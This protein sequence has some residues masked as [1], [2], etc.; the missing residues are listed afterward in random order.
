MSYGYNNGGCGCGGTVQYAPPACNPNFPTY[1]TKLGDGN[2][3]R[4]VGEDS[5]YCKYT[6]PTPTSNSILT[7]NA[8]TGLINW[9]DGSNTNPIYLGSVALD[10]SLSNTALIQGLT[11]TGQLVGFTPSGYSS[12]TRF[13]VVASGQSNAT[14]GTIESVI[15]NQGV[16]Y[17]NASNVVAQAALG[18]SGQV[19]T[20]NSS[21]V[22][23]FLNSTTPA[24]I[25]AQAIN[26][27][28]A[29]TTTINVSFGS[30]V[31]NSF[32]SSNPQIVANGSASTYTLAINTYGPGAMDIAANETVANTYYYVY[33]IYDNTNKVFNVVGSPSSTQ[34]LTTN[35][36]TY[37]YYRLIGVFY[38]G[39]NNLISSGYYQNGNNVYFGNGTNSNWPLL[40]TTGTDTTH[41]FFSN[42]VPNANLLSTSVA[43]VAKMVFLGYKQPASQS[44]TLDITNTN[45]S[46]ASP[47]NTNYYVP[48]GSEIYGSAIYPYT[49][50]F[51]TN[52]VIIVYNN[53]TV[54][55]PKTGTIYAILNIGAVNPSGA[56]FSAYITGYT[57]NIF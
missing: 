29:S 2:I 50:S 36:G 49:Y 9:A 47:T 6:V 27:Y 21:G 43:K 51:T 22:P 48:I 38:T 14:W 37:T 25:D 45:P 16:V 41:V 33:A 3:Q 11:P 10:E 18:T 57:L 13:P 52:P 56:Y 54:D 20:I 44:A 26:L 30:L 7:Y 55:I 23:Q 31:F 46:A 28:Y 34:P 35:L 40:F 39:P 15:P 8:S 24:F 1:C 17:K 5:A 53:F 42:I 19:L 32:N 12:E 4:V